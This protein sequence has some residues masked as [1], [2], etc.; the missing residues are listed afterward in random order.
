MK[1]ASISMSLSKSSWTRGNNASIKLKQA[2]EEH[3]LKNLLALFYLEDLMGN[4]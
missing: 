1:A 3:F 2:V 4:P